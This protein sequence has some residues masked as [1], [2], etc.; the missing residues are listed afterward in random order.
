METLNEAWAYV[1][2]GIVSRYEHKAR[3]TLCK[4]PYATKL[5]FNHVRTSHSIMNAWLVWNIKIDIKE[6]EWEYEVWMQ[7]AY[8][9][10]GNRYRWR[11]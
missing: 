2:K 6:T 10:N 11:R 3:Y 1:A 5:L 8:A 4:Q 9:N 7:L